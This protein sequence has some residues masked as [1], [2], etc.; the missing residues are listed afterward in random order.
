MDDDNYDEIREAIPVFTGKLIDDD[1]DID[2]FENFK[3]SI[4]ADNTLDNEIKQV[5]INSRKEAIKK[6][7]KKFELNMERTLRVGTIALLI[8]K[9]K[10]NNFRKITQ[11][12][13]DFILFQIEKWIEGDIKIINLDS[14]ILYSLFELIDEIEN[15]TDKNKIKN[16]FEPENKIDYLNYV[17]MMDQIKLSSIK[18]END[19]INIQKYMKLRNDLLN[20]LMFN[21]TKMSSMDP[22][23]KLLKEQLTIPINKFIE[24]KTELI[25]LDE[26][27]KNKTLKF[28]NSIR[29]K[30]EDKENIIGLLNHVNVKDQNKL[31]S[32]E[33]EQDITNIKK[34]RIELKNNLLNELMFNLTKMS[35]MDPDSKLLKEQLTI[36]INKFIELET[37]LIELDE[38]LKNKTLKFLNSIRIKKEDKEN[39]INLLK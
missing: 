29:I 28:L 25:E 19:R 14:D 39:I 33:E 7:E 38:D 34:Q 30:K 21:L 27:L 22:D 9:I 15:Y 37:E 36:P 1:D 17:D 24:F 12:Q 5:I 32:I 3:K 13:K 4:L 6:F 11:N 2:N 8:V 18:E 23:S 35:S 31:R 20:E 26:D 10:N 16:I